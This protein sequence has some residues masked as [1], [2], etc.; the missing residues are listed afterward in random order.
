[1]RDGETERARESVCECVC[2]SAQN[3]GFKTDNPITLSGFNS[4]SF[5]DQRAIINKSF[6]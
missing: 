3:P 5:L 4:K 6:P 2:A 1:M